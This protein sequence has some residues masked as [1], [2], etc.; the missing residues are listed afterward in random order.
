MAQYLGARRAIRAKAS[1]S[2]QQPRASR[3]LQSL[4]HHLHFGSRQEQ[5]SHSLSHAELGDMITYPLQFDWFNP[6]TLRCISN[7]LVPLSLLA[8]I[9]YQILTEEQRRVFL[10][11]PLC[12][13]QSQ[14]A[15]PGRRAR[16]LPASPFFPLPPFTSP[17]VGVALPLSALA[18]G[19]VLE[20]SAFGSSRGQRWLRFL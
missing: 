2:G 19:L 20:E 1:S 4:A 14:G 7:Y 5:H 17:R 18:V 6:I 12:R 9:I 15:L 11:P 16:P 8:C 10:P 13:S 3:R